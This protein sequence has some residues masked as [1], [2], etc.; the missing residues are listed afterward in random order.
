VPAPDRRWLAPALA[1]TAV[2]LVAASLRHGMPTSWDG[3]VY[4]QGS[5]SLLEG[6]GFRS[7]DGEPIRD[8]PPLYPLVLAA[9]QSALGVSARSL[10]LSTALLTGLGVLAWG[11]LVRWYAARRGD[12]SRVALALAWVTVLL[13]LNARDLRAESLTRA[14][15]PLLL[16]ATL[17]GGAA[18]G[19]RE[20]FACAGAAAGV[21]AAMMFARNAALAFAP[22][23]AVVFALARGVAPGRRLLAAAVAAGLPLACW[24]LLRLLLDQGGS[25]EVGAGAGRHPPWSYLL[26]LLRGVDRATNL[27]FVGLPLLVALGAGLLRGDATRRETPPGPGGREGAAL[28]AFVAVSAVALLG[29]FSVT[30]VADRL[31]GRFVVWVP[32]A[33]GALGIVDSRRLLTGRL[34]A[35]FL[36]VLFLQ[37]TLRVAKHAARGRG[38]AEAGYALPELRDFVPSRATIRP[39]HVRLAPLR[40]A[41]CVVVSP[42]FPEALAEP[43]PD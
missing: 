37:P 39:G 19:T 7:F 17:R 15:L 10:A 42:P 2:A 33:I 13:V 27:D 36:L 6:Q 21:L 22:G 30:D 43:K 8:W 9:L 35:L 5:V 28:L 34:A 25:H 32:L 11:G 26:Q 16:W 3:W 24:L 14:L 31:R 38:D 4:W 29:L 18:A 12:G 20:L 41:G 1:L 40:E 23:V